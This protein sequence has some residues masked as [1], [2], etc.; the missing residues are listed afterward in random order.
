M[1]LAEKL[2]GLVVRNGRCVELMELVFKSG[3]ASVAEA[4]K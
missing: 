4:K 2:M 3:E 1:Q